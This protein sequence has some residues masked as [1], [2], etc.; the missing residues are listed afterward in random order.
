MLSINENKQSLYSMA[1]KK[2]SLIKEF[3]TMYQNVCKQSNSRLLKEA[4]RLIYNINSIEKRHN[5]SKCSYVEELKYEFNRSIFD[6]DYIHELQ[7]K[8]L[9]NIPVEPRVEYIKGVKL[10]ND[11][12]K[13]V[14]TIV[15]S[16][17]KLYK[18]VEKY[19]DKL[20]EIY[21]DKTMSSSI[22]SLFSKIR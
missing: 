20:L 7:K 3:I 13:D 9:D 12:N 10:V 2:V 4:N 19:K 14:I 17:E 6:K 11:I 21:P 15:V 18:K 22:E 1:S 16:L 8:S 5:Y